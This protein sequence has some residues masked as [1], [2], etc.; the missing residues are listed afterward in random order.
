MLLSET[1]FFPNWPCAGTHAH[2]QFLV[3]CDWGL[4]SERTPCVTTICRAI[5]CVERGYTVSLQNKYVDDKHLVYNNGLAWLTRALQAFWRNMH[6]TNVQHDHKRQIQQLALEEPQDYAT[7]DYASCLNDTSKCIYLLCLVH[8]SCRVGTYFDALVR[9][10]CSLCLTKQI[11]E[12]YLL[13]RRPN[14]ARLAFLLAQGG[15]VIDSKFRVISEVG[16]F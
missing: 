2:S 10:H 16:W 15:H 4:K 8:A 1:Y 7:L 11:R 14:R 13:R 6:H 5:P 9:C 3:R 12:A